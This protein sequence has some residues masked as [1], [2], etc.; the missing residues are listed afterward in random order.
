MKIPESTKIICLGN[1]FSSEE[2]RRQY[3]RNELRAKLPELKKIEGFP[4]GEDEDIINLSDPPYYTAC[5]NP[6]L[7]D[8]IAEWE[9][10]KE[11]ILERKKDFHVDEPYAGDVTEGKNNPIYNAHSYHTKVPHPAIMRYILHYTQPGDIVLDAFAGT[12]MTGVA[13]TLCGNPDTETK[14]LIESE[15]IKSNSQ[16]PVWGKRQCINSDLSP[17]ASHISAVY[18]NGNIKNEINDIEK[19]INQ[20]EEELSFL[21]KTKINGKEHT[22]NYL[23]WSS[24]IIC[25]T[26]NKTSNYF[27]IAYNHKGLS[28]FKRLNQV[29]CPYCKATRGSRALPIFFTTNYN[30]ISKETERTAKVNLS[31]V[32]YYDK[33]TKKLKIADN[34]DELINEKVN[35]LLRTSAIPKIL[36]P[37]GVNLGQPLKSHGYKYLFHFYPE[38]TLLVIDRFLKLCQNLKSNIPLFIL[39]S[40]LPKLTKLNRYM[41]EHG[42][43]ALVGP[44][45][46]TLYI[47]PLFVE[48][49]AIEQIKYQFTKIAKA[50]NVGG[51]N[52]IQTCSATNI[53][54]PENSI[55]YIFTDPP[56]G[57][58]IMYSELNLLSESWLKIV[59]NNKQEAITNDFQSK[60]VLDYQDI[61][62]ACFKEYFR[63][64]KPGKWITVEF[65]NSSAAVWNAIQYALRK[66]GFLIVTVDILNKERP[67]FVGMIG[68]NAVKEDLA[69]TCL[70][71]NRDY[72]KHNNP[73]KPE[74]TVWEITQYI[75]EN[76]AIFSIKDKKSVTVISRDP[77]V[78]WDRVVSFYLVN[79]LTLPIDLSRYQEGLKQR[80]AERDG[81]FFTAEQVAEYDDKKAKTP[82]FVQ[83]SLIVTNES[84]AIEWLKD[85]LRKQAQ[86]YQD[87]MPDFRIATQ[88]L[89]KGDT[90]P[91]LQDI[92]N[93]NFIQ[94]SDGR[95]R[96][97]DPNEAKDRDAL[98][99]KVLLKE[100]NGY[101][102]AISQPRAKKLKEVRVEALR[103]GFKNCW[104]QKDFKSI[105]TLGDMIPQNILLEDEQLLM[106]YD[107]ARDRI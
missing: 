21:Y 102:T 100:F 67:G 89:R 32:N 86:K 62:I 60:T 45:A 106:Y 31:L 6:W 71:P 19:I 104:E 33:K 4:I 91:E 105:V 55:D 99:T 5:P 1:E 103:A 17:I 85:R 52:L 48:N 76:S 107:I 79:G 37:D 49:N 53:L 10:E 3:F 9:K 61:M 59:T 12:G 73:N 97:P 16:V 90:L 66:A 42:G 47:P 28:S 56:F 68:P 40:A 7:N 81:M 92:L 46:N 95:W 80:F 25:E 96:T 54:L 75:L 18:N 22:I 51:K 34:Y 69:I 44:R 57:G 30:E 84:D 94:E 72:S 64:L 77:R 83:L 23:V 29:V 2:E 93:E 20:L 82:Q 24:V 26:C 78:L 39:T 14:Y 87:I 11:K 41:P 101:V 74:N 43:R 27:D 65:S 15:S 63:V 58:N 38:R 13:S 8:F 50:V 88:S 36:N 98:R 35:E 70:K